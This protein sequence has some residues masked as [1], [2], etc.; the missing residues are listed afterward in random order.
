[1]QSLQ[2]RRESTASQVP[3]E[4]LA[5]P[6]GTS[7]PGGPSIFD[8]LI[9]EEE[10]MEGSRP[11]RKR[12]SSSSAPDGVIKRRKRESLEE[13]TK[14]AARSSR[15]QSKRHSGGNETEGE[16]R[17]ESH[18]PATSHSAQDASSRPRRQKQEPSRVRVLIKERSRFMVAFK[19]DLSRV[20]MPKPPKPPRRLSEIGR[21]HV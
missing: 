8:T 9:I 14:D 3:K 21:A 7:K 20:R 15:S 1:M 5:A 12:K 17:V 4:L 6:R 18:R 11:L 13:E 2:K 16:V 19:V 10:E